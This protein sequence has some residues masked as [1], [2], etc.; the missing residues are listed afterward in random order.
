[1]GSNL[2]RYALDDARGQHLRV[3]PQCEFVAA[4]IQEH[5]EYQY[6]TA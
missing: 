1:M 5:A 4:F 6:L 2:I 3:V